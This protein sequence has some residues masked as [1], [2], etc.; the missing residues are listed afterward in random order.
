MYQRAFVAKV[1]VDSLGAKPFKCLLCIDLRTGLQV[2]WP[3]IYSIL[4]FAVGVNI[5]LQE[6]DHG[7]SRLVVEY[8][9][10]ARRNFIYAGEPLLDLNKESV[11]FA[12]LLPCLF[13]FLIILATCIS[14]KSRCSQIS[15]M[16]LDAQS[17]SGRDAGVLQSNNCMYLRR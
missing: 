4:L 13:I 10:V 14:E 17:Q 15:R 6:I 8:E 12:C 2:N 9:M 3:G 1:V 7:V 5:G 16:H 11:Y